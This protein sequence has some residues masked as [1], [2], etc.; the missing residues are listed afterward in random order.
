MI[1]RDFSRSGKDYIKQN[2]II[3][4]VLAIIF[5]AGIIMMSVLGF[6]GNA[7]IKGYTTFSINMEET[8]KSD[9]LSDYEKKVNAELVDS[10]CGLYSI[11]IA[12]EAD[13]AKLIVKYKGTPKDVATLNQNIADAI[14]IDVTA[15]SAHNKVKPSITSS[16]YIYAV[17]CGLIIVTLMT[18]Y[19]GIRYNWACGIS[20]VTGSFVSILLLLCVTSILRLP[21]T[22]AFLAINIITLVLVFFESLMLFDG[23]EKERELLKDKNDRATQMTNT[24]KKNAVRQ[25]I[26]FGSIFAICLIMV[27]IAP[28]LIKQTALTMLFGIIVAMFVAIYVL[29]FVWNLTITKISDRIRIKKDKKVKVEKTTITEGELEKRYTENQVIEVKEDSGEDTPSNDDNITVE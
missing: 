20:V 4:I 22:S 9:K 5:V 28:S 25:Q 18:L 21:V 26:M 11:Q 19:V 8:L 6:N 1:N 24:I 12:G 7:D 29:P 3:L 23:L 16:D 17:A 2:K 13:S 27:F 14:N 10:G 15:I